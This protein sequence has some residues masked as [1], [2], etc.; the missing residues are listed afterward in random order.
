MAGLSKIERPSLV[1]MV[2]P[3][4]A[5]KGG[6]AAVERAL[7]GAWDHD[8]Y[9]VRH[10]ATYASHHGT[11]ARKLGS[12]IPALIRVAWA[13]AIWQP[14]IVHVHVSQ[15]GSILRKSVVVMLAKV[16]GVKAVL[17]HAHASNFHTI[18]EGSGGPARRWI[19]A[20]LRSADRLIVLGSWW[21]RY[22]SSLSLSRPIDVLPNPIV[23]PPSPGPYGERP[24]VV[25]T[26]GELG[27]RK[28]TYDTL[29]AIPAI[30]QAHPG[31]EFW[32]GGDGDIER[33]RAIIDQAPWGKRVRLL[34]WVEG[35]AKD[36]ALAMA[37]VFLL[38]SYNEGLPVAVLEAM[39]H[40]VPIVTTPVGD[41]PDAVIDGQTGFLVTPGDA[42]AIA[43]RVSLLLRDSA[44]GAR[45]GARARAHAAAVFDVKAIM[46]RL[47]AIYDL[48]S[49]ATTGEKPPS[50]SEPSE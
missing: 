35:A 11:N 19:R 49:G 5:Q 34:G 25:L 17:L 38:P 36:R 8:R 31:A 1:L 37:R 28:G 4:L 42:D 45:M 18:Y 23:C 21:Q 32:L 33:V 26:L 22:F 46:P 24:F 40:G 48:A 2:G 6:M 16:F 43:E 13:M 12:A 14:Q 30:L 15:R 3:A 44:L 9:R 41:I 10:V 39:A 47:F 50:T 27:E 20:L 29:R 7:L